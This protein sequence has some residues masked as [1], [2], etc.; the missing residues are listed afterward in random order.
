MLSIAPPYTPKA[1]DPTAEPEYDIIFT[2]VTSSSVS[3]VHFP[4]AWSI[5]FT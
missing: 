5:I 3:G 4:G 2:W 1:S